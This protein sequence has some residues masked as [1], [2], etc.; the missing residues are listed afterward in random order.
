MTIKDNLDHEVEDLAADEY[1]A[2]LSE[3]QEGVNPKVAA[4]GTAG[5]VTVVLVWALA[6]AGVELPPE[7]ASAFTTLIAFAAGWLKTA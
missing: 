5:A 2:E 6:Q 4:G 1:E 7:V 3:V